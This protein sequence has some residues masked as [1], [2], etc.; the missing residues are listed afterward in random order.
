MR[1][2][3]LPAIPLSK[4]ELFPRRPVA[5]LFMK[6]TLRALAHKT[7]RP[8]LPALTPSSNGTPCYKADLDMSQ[9]ELFPRTN[10]S[11]QLIMSLPLYRRARR[12]SGGG[13]SFT[14][15]L[16]AR[17]CWEPVGAEDSVRTLSGLCR[18]KSAPPLQRAPVD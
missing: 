6:G 8:L 16:L 14:P 12:G 11:G 2:A 4:V 7:V 17:V 18:A 1:Q 5:A 10:A 9:V 13:L 15:G 3:L